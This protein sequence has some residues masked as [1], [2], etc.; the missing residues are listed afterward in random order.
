MCHCEPFDV[1]EGAAISQFGHGKGYLKNQI[2]K[3]LPRTTIQGQNHIS[4]TKMIA[5][6]YLP[7]LVEKRHHPERLVPY[8]LPS[9]RTTESGSEGSVLPHPPSSPI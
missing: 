5:P 7:T 3:N 9:I 8:E 4:K 6:K 2:S 1:V